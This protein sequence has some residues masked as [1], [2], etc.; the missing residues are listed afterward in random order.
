MTIIGT[1]GPGPA[2]AHRVF[3]AAPQD[4]SQVGGVE[5]G[6]A[7][8][9][10]A[11]DRV[12]RLERDA[13][14]AERE[15]DEQRGTDELA[16]TGDRVCI[17]SVM[18]VTQTTV[19]PSHEASSSPEFCST[20][21]LL[22]AGAGL[23]PS[24]PKLVCR[25]GR[26]SKGARE[27]WCRTGRGRP[28]TPER[29]LHTLA[30]ALAPPVSHAAALAEM[31]RLADAGTRAGRAGRCRTQRSGRCF[32]I[33]RRD[34]SHSPSPSTCAR[35]TDAGG[36]RVKDMRLMG[37]KKVGQAARLAV[38]STAIFAGGQSA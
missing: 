31:E 27:G 29:L 15:E 34:K 6:G 1:S 38:G 20:L 30:Q 2:I 24:V 16:Q 8:L 3:L 21:G 23:L 12:L 32:E 36:K 37:G 13:R 7:V 4:H 22:G 25:L 9:D 33:G 17:V 14:A 18:V 28:R 5:G 35:R 11:G 19:S 26:G 10:V